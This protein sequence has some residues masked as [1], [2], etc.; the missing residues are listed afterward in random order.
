MHK[1]ADRIYETSVTTGTGTY[2]LAGAATGFQSFSTLGAGATTPYF[3][4]DDTNW[5]VGIGTVATGPNTLARTVILASSNANAAVNWGV[6]TRKIRVGL[7][8]EMA[9]AD[10]VCCGRLTLATG[11]PVTTADQTGKSSVFFSPYKGSV[12]SLY[13][14]AA[15]INYN[16]TEL[17]LA[18]PATTSQM[19]DVFLK[20]V[21]GTLTLS[22][23]AW[24]NDTTRATALTT[25]DG[26]YVKTGDTSS[27]YLGS[28]RTTGVSGQTEDSLAKRYL[29]NYYNRSRRPMKV[30]DTTDTWNYT[31]LTYRQANAAAANQLDFVIG[32]A[33]DAVVAEVLA[34]ATNA[35]SI[36]IFAGIGLDSTTTSS[37]TLSVR[38]I[39]AGTGEGNPRAVYTGFPAVGRHTLVWLEMS[40]ASGTTTWQ[41]DN[42]D[43]TKVQCGIFGEVLG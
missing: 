6:G 22:A 20:N 4:T 15:W 38:G 39:T 42:G 23:L 41:G 19:Y 1:V 27:L 34:A 16:F 29:W 36:S 24:T 28:F 2:T 8:A 5:E 40:V 31:L 11:T 3:A 18:V 17:T 35:G 43:A 25:Q 32:V 26:V 10:Q 12:V 7:P 33:E 21:A 30:S 37:A 9:L 13:N 14:G